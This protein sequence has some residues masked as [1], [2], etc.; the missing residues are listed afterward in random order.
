MTAR[1]G[2]AL[3][4]L[5]A[6]GT[7]LAG[8]VT[9]PVFAQTASTAEGSPSTADIIVTANRR[10][11][12]LVDVPMSVVAVSSDTV[13]KA[14]VVSVHDINRIAPGVQIN[15]AGCCTQPAVRG[16]SSLT[17]GIGFE[18]NVAIYVDGFYAPDNLSI[19]GDVSNLAN[20][21]VLKGPQGTLW[22]RNATGGAILM[23]TKRP[24]DTLTGSFQIG[25]ASFNEVTAS[26][27]ASGPLTD[28][29]RVSLSAY[30][31][32]GDGYY[33]LLDTTGKVVGDAAP[34]HQ[35][36]VRFKAEIDLGP[37]TVATIGANY[38]LASDPRGSLFTVLQ[39]PNPALPQPPA[40]ADRPFTASYN[41][42][43]KSEAV[44]REITLKLVQEAGFG[45]ITS[46]TGYAKR[47]TALAYDFDA[48]YA[49]LLH[50]SADWDQKTFQQ[51]L[52]VNI[53]SIDGVNLV[54]GGSYYHDRLLSDS[55]LSTGAFS[56]NAR[57][58]TLLTA[59]ALA[60]YVD[61][62]IDITDKLVIS[63]GA[64]YTHESK[65]ADYSRFSRTTGLLN[66]GPFLGDKSFNAFTPRAS[67][68]YA[69]GDRSNVYA[70]FSRGFRSGGYNPNGSVTQATF[71]PF[72]PEKITAYEVGFKTAQS[73]FQF[74][75]STFYYD[76]RDLQVG[77]T[78][79]IPDVGLVNAV[80]N[81]PKAEVLGVDAML[82]A[83]PVKDLNIRIG[84]AYLHGRYRNFKNVTAIGLNSTTGQ[85]ITDQLQ[86][87]SGK[88]MAR[89]PELTGNVSIDYTVRDVAGGSVTLGGNVQ[90][91]SGF[92]TNNAS[93]Y[94]P[95]A[96][97]ELRGKQR[98]RQD[99]YATANAQ[100]SWTDAGDNLKLTVYVNNLTDK[101]YRMS[102]NGNFTGDY[103]TFAQPRTWGV[104]FGYDY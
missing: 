67:I 45:T 47:D 79:N 74:E 101:V 46:Y 28:A 52:D 30:N 72:K 51:T 25:Y 19:N 98:Y 9:A 44:V 86:D 48:T 102:Y 39:Y 75:A 33:K 91:S 90:Y 5:L 61:G 37:K 87:W 96:A 64:R 7:A 69:L 15:F 17:T 103:A 41:A 8:L 43:T 4:I 20:I 34:V 27:Y 81:A 88:Q 22:G 35:A 36:S 53:S 84:G 16:I 65:K 100:V 49:T 95:L 3:K 21:E 13:E 63:A 77:L 31:R 10:N 89:A 94:G 104:R 80:F 56:P 60:G 42:E 85:N 78:R 38:A 18:N 70:S 26:G 57:T 97:V 66:R 29:I 92:A 40:R 83:E 12:K 73:S 76:F 32:K 6:S 99:A 24:S 55:Q 82:T 58:R 71:L 2:I 1:G 23:N 68:R 50:S 59:E 93:L 11:E 62:S 54:V 14:G